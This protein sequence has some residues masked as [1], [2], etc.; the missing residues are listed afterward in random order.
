MSFSTFEISELSEES[1]NDYAV[2]IQTSDSMHGLL[3]SEEEMRM[4]GDAI[5]R[6]VED[7]ASA[8]DQLHVEDYA[9]EE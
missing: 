4:L 1:D 6:T 3:I 5:Q 9:T 2:E 7:S 8:A